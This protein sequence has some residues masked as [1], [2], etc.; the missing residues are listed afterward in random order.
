MEYFPE[1]S[2]LFALYRDQSTTIEAE[3]IVQKFPAQNSLSP[4]VIFEF[5]N[6]LQLQPG[7]FA[8]DRS[9]GFPKSLALGI[10]EAFHLDLNSGFWL[11]REVDFAQ[12][13]SLARGLS[14]KHTF[15]G[16]HRAMDILHVATALHWGAREFLTFDERQ[17]RLA[18]AAGL[19]CPLKVR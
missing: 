11:R 12:V 18:K 10:H 8:T 5:E 1:T 6:S 9:K 13:L 19:K 14:E 16:L 17:V 3:R 4:L 15:E 7:L 2:F